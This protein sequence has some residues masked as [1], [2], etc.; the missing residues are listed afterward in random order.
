MLPVQVVVQYGLQLV[1]RDGGPGVIS[2]PVD[3]GRQVGHLV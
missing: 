2:L 3:G 1:T